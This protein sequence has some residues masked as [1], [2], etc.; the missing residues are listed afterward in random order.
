MKPLLKKESGFSNTCIL[1]VMFST[2]L[3][4]MLQIFALWAWNAGFI[5]MLAV[6]L[7]H[8]FC[9]LFFFGI[10][11]W[12]RRLNR[13]CSLADIACPIVIV[14][15][16]V[17]AMGIFLT[18]ILYLWYRRKA[19]PF[20]IWYREILPDR[21]TPPEERLIERL[22][23]WG[24]DADLQNREPIP[25]AD[26][27]SSGGIAEKQ[28]AITLMLRNFHPSFAPAFRQALADPDNAVRVQAASAITHIEE[29]FF[30]ENLVLERRKSTHPNDTEN[31]AKLAK[32]YD[33]HA[34]AGLG[35]SE[36]SNEL[37]VKADLTYREL[38][39]KQ[40]E[41]ATLWLHG[42]LLVR[43][44]RLDEATKIFEMALTEDNDNIGLLQRIWY[45][46]CLYEQ[47]R[48]TELR[49]RIAACRE[50]I[51]DETILPHELLDSIGLW[52]IEDINQELA[53]V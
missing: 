2:I 29:I 14:L 27:L 35:G 53:R 46:E 21:I 45:W 19:T 49:A 9:G 20:E 38:Y 22:M 8:I 6:L 47:H 32:H 3:V 36:T 30:A 44:G 40:P 25:F 28:Y 12:Y 11:R 41:N 15:G 34:S 13:D 51:T 23:I 52:K 31:L 4:A 26:I 17:G 50:H 7:T 16:F 24:E 10:S 48:Y 39:E 5:S 42:R 1:S 33:Q 37:R 43:S 18:S